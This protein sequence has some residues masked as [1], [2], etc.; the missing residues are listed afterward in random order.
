[1]KFSLSLSR[2]TIQSIVPNIVDVFEQE[3]RKQCLKQKGGSAPRTQGSIQEG[4][5]HYLDDQSAVDR[6]E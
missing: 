1:M 2:R 4:E 5:K 6:I 3:D